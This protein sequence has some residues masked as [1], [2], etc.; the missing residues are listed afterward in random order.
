MNS[1]VP[2]DSEEVRM[3]DYVDESVFLGRIYAILKNDDYAVRYQDALKS[4]SKLTQFMVNVTDELSHQIGMRKISEYYTIDHVFYREEDR[5]PEGALPFGTSR[6]SG[7]WLK[8]IRVA[9]EHENR[10]DTA[11]GF[12]EVAKLM[13]INADMKVL[14]GYANKG[15]NYD[16]Y[17]MEYQEIFNCAAHQTTPILFVGE[18]LNTSAD[19]YLLTK[20]GL[21]K[22]DWITATWKWYNH[23]K[24]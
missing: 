22:Y 23:E 15:E 1:E 5:I 21:L 10:L 7:T 9:F 8:R 3:K 13:L 18:Y 20:N 4:D 17:A 12:Q 16:M 14:M 19:A 24:L 11:G 2:I 6:V